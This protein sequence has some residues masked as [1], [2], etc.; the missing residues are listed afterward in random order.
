[1]QRLATNMT[2]RIDSVLTLALIELIEY[3]SDFRFVT[4]KFEDIFVTSTT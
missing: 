2:G 1:M 3:K 4:I